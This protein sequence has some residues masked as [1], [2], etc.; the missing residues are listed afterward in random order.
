MLGH[1]KQWEFLKKAFLSSQLSHGYL[2]SGLQ[3]LGKRNL[4][5]EFV[6]MLN[7]RDLNNQPCNTCASCKMIDARSHP[8]F[9]L[10]EPELGKDIKIV[11][12]RK[13]I[14]QLDL[15]P[16]YS[17]FKTA[18]IDQAHLM[19]IQ[20]QNCFLKTLEE[21]KGKTVLILVTQ[22]KESLIG[23]IKSRI[24]ELKFSPVSF[25]QIQEIV[26]TENV[27]KNDLQEI[28]Q[29]SLGRPM[30]V[31]D[32]IQNPEKLEKEKNIKKD[33]LEILSSD[34]K[35]RFEYVESLTKKPLENTL[36]LWLKYLR[37]ILLD[38]VDNDQDVSKIKKAIK[39]LEK[40]IYLVSN[41]NIS[42]RLALES[43]ILEI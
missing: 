4:A 33:L 8:D 12:V 34:L 22:Y 32:L 31:L 36:E 19:N 15:K 5:I 1:D 24:Q 17:G 42:K 39:N 43:L 11:Q 26:K 37:E 28:S 23:T 16:F 30:R 38:K 14:S 41:T 35:T 25:K 29:F 18:I 3:G 6:K 21:P 27:S 10:T 13:L 9:V 2:F 40:T 20:A 7:C